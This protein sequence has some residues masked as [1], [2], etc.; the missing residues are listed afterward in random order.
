M[1]EI[2]IKRALLAELDT[3]WA[4]IERICAGLNAADMV[5]LEL[6]KLCA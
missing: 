3:E 6:V 5:K 1:N 4:N 2:S